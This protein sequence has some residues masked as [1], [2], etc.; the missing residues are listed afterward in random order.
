M[1]VQTYNAQ[2]EMRSDKIIKPTR[3]GRKRRVPGVSGCAVG[4]RREPWGNTFPSS[5]KLDPPHAKLGG[6]DVGDERRGNRSAPTPQRARLCAVALCAPL[7]RAPVPVRGGGAR[8]LPALRLPSGAPSPVRP[9]VPPGLRRRPA[10]PRMP[11]APRVPEFRPHSTFALAHGRARHLGH[12]CSGSKT[13]STL[14]LQRIRMPVTRRCP[15]GPSASGSS[16][17]WPA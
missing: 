15:A 3:Y 9:G 16:S 6:G 7:R 8:E 2:K 5:P 10:S 4:P 12:A 13:K 17:A 14:R 11:P 1:Q